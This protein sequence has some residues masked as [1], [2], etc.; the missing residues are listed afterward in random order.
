[1]IMPHIPDDVLAKV[2]K[3]VKLMSNTLLKTLQ[4]GGTT[5]FVANGVAA[6]QKAPH[7]LIHVFPRRENDGLVKL[8]KYEMSDEQIE[9]LKISL[10]QYTNQIFGG[11]RKIIKEAEF[12]EKKSNREEK[13]HEE[14]HQTH[15]EDSSHEE[16][17]KKEAKEIH[18]K[19][20]EPEK[21]NV[22]KDS[23]MKVDLDD[24]AKLFGG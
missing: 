12:V 22:K 15:H 7:T 5:V 10:G 24:I 20:D 9:K 16:H 1:M 17:T 11:R 13:H 8:P 6:G 21:R 3:N 4:C 14:T 23:K 18:K 2:F 19:N